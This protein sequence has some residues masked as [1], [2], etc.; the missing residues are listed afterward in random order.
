M[1]N[2]ILKKKEK[3][4]KDKAVVVQLQKDKAKAHMLEL[5]KAKGKGKK[6]QIVSEDEEEEAEE[7][8]AEPEKK[9]PEPAV[10]KEEEITLV[11]DVPT[12]WNS[13]IAML[14]SA[15]KMKE[16]LKRVQQ[17]GPLKDKFTLPTDKEWE[18]IDHLRSALMPVEILTKLLCEENVT[19]LKA[20]ALF[21]GA[22]RGLCSFNNAVATDLKLKTSDAR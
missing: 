17:K 22:Y 1:Y 12:R 19:I 8:E 21:Q 2:E 16:A 5:K 10:Q 3:A 7:K 13:S 6:R 9:E 18:A 14:A 4:K 15:L 20:E 11:L